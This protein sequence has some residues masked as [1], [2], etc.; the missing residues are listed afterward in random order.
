MNTPLPTGS[1]VGILGGGQLGRMLAMAAAR[2]GYRVV[3]FDPDPNAPAA[4]L[5]NSHICANYDDNTALDQLAEACDVITYEFENVPVQAVERLDR[6]V[7]VRPGAKALRIAQD[8]LSEKIMAGGLGALTAE[9]ASVLNREDLVA[10]LQKTGYPAVLKTTRLGYDGKGQARI[11]NEKEIDEALAVMQG[12]PAIL[13]SFVHFDREVSVLAARGLD[14]AVEVFDLAE[15]DH[16]H[17]ILHTST[18][19]ANLEAQAQAEA[20]EIATAMLAHLDYIGVLAV[21]FFAVPGGSSHSLIVNEIAPRVHN[22]GHWTEAACVVSQFEQHIRAVCGL[23]LVGAA[24]HSDCVMENLIGDDIERLNALA[25]EE[26]VFIHL[27]GKAE[28]RTGRKMGH[29]TRLTGA[30]NKA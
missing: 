8:R 16:R 2:F 15:N 1:T 21:E 26:N 25:N 23:P 3:I 7:P 18:V 4:Q 9:F 22:S 6:T 17:H 5:A 11:A 19:P 13:E 29:F 28:A 12:A 24:R 14:G 10:G 20:R 27:Y 30:A